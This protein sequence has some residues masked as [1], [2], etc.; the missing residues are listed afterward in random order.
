MIEPGT[1]CGSLF[2]RP[3]PYK[4][5]S[6][7]FSEKQLQRLDQPFKGMEHLSG[8][9]GH[10]PKTVGAVCDPAVFAGVVELPPGVLGPRDG[11][12]LVDLVEPGCEPISWP[13]ELYRQETFKDAAPWLVI[14]IF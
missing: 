6:G 4:S 14:R 12:V 13:G 3:V 9:A 7:K 11:V 10:G 2:L 5:D 1:S 8:W